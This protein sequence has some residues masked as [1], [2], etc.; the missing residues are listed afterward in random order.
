MAE[1]ALT[2]PERRLLLELNARG[3]RFLVV[4]ASAA[5]LQGANTATQDIALWFADLADPAIGE[6]VR[7][8]GGIWI[9][10]SVGMRPP[11][12]GGDAIGD[13]LDEFEAELARSLAVDV[14]GVP[15]RVLPIDRVIASKRALGR[16]RDLAHL[17]ALEEAVAAI[18]GDDA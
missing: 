11:A 9:P 18:D 7:A 12:I 10:G 6:A 4:G 1:S 16:P 3:V 17:P 5:V 14:E 15:L 13:R 8:A 2:D